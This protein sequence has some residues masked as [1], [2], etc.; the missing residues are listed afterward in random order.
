VGL[1]T[2]AKSDPGYRGTYAGDQFTRDGAYHNG[3]VWP[4]LIGAF[5]EAYLKVN[6]RSSASLDQA[7]AWLAP[8]ITHMTDTGAIGQISE[9]FEGDEPH[10]PVGCPAQAWSIAEV[11]RLAVDLGV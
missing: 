11:L 6:A 4:W 9:I 5:I 1:R 3:T 8:L 10:R 2:L 7:R